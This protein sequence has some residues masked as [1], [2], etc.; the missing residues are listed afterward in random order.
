MSVSL[1]NSS[2]DI[3][4]SFPEENDIVLD[5]KKKLI[6]LNYNICDSSVVTKS[7]DLET[8]SYSEISEHILNLFKNTRCIIVCLSLKSLKTHLQ[9]IEM[10]KLLDNSFEYNNNKIIYLITDYSYI[11][12][13]VGGITNNNNYFPCYNEKSFNYSFKK[14]VEIL[15]LVV[16]K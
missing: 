6:D 15:Q 4:L 5:L 2:F 7:L 16:S 14:L 8:M 12:L 11:T 9:I 13:L 3:Y 1:N 10:N